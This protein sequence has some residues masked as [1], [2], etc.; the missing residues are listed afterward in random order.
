MKRTYQIIMKPSTLS[1]RE[2]AECLSKD[3]AAPLY[4]G[5]AVTRWSAGGPRSG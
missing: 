3:G 5:A 1:S 2:F 4:L